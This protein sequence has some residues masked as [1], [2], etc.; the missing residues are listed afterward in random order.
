MV[1]CGLCS[2][3]SAE[4]TIVV[5]P[6]T[7]TIKVIGDTTTGS[8]STVSSGAVAGSGTTTPN[9]PAAA[10]GSTTQAPSSPTTTTPKT[11]FDRALAWMYEK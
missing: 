7:K 4:Q 1:V 10:T 9:T 6:I 11:E 2:V 5:D 8:G 3:V